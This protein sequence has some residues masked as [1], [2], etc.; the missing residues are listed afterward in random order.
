MADYPNSQP[1]MADYGHDDPNNWKWGII[2]FNKQ[3]PRILPPKR[4][5]GFGWTINFANPKSITFMIFI[6]FLIMVLTSI[7]KKSF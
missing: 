1:Q 4:I 2:Y 6:I 7:A 3:D 5:A